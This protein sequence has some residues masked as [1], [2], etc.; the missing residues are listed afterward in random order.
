MLVFG[1]NANTITGTSSYLNGLLRQV[2]IGVPALDGT[3][4]ATFTLIDAE[5]NTVYTKAT[6][7]KSTT[8]INLL[9]ANSMVPLNGTYT[10]KVVTSGDQTANRTFTATLLIER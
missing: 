10:L 4:T 6:I 9:D 3:D 1:T 5:S 2:I 8:S 7:A